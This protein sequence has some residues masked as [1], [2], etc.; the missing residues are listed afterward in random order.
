MGVSVL[1][2]SSLLAAADPRALAIA[3][4]SRQGLTYSDLRVLV[5]RIHRM[6]GLYRLKSTDT[7]A[8]ALRNGPET[9]ALFVALVTY[10]R[11]A[12]LNPGATRDEIAFALRDLEATA[13]VTSNG[14]HEAISA[15][16][17]CGV[18]RMLLVP[19]G[20]GAFEL[21]SESP[22][23][24]SLAL[25][26]PPGADDIAMLLH[27]SGTT[28]RPKL[29]PIT[30]RNLALSTRGVVDS[31]QLS[32]SDTCLSLMPL[33]HVHGIVAGLLA[34][35]AAG[36][37]VCVAPGFKAAA[38]F[39]WL[40]SSRATWYTAVPTIHQAIL[41][42]ARHNR[43]ALDRSKLRFIRSCSSALYPSVYSELGSVFGVP[44]LNAYGMTEAA[45][46]IS[47]VRLPGAPCATVGHGSGPEIAI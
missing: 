26:S 31:L 10:C 13:L 45:H 2:I 11:V 42:R 36:A 32:P 5:D 47:S 38:F 7:V 24:T 17:E 1:T 21:K 18:P 28:A 22:P 16:E 3:D 34:S 14:A 15:A 29:V 9:A 4:T 8:F 30:Q 12:P 46:Q 33:F 19:A 43:D 25:H 23:R 20:T 37:A 40:D 35:L 44:V 27:T 41:V 39:S 6:L